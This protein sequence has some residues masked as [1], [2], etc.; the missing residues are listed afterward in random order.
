MT[1]LLV[2]SMSFFM[3]LL[4][5]DISKTF[6]IISGLLLFMLTIDQKVKIGICRTCKKVQCFISDCY[7][8]LQSS[9]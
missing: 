1:I 4:V 9:L 3:K 7:M 2:V 6:K 5:I 8:L